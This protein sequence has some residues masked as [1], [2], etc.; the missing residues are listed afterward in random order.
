MQVRP[1]GGSI[2]EDRRT[3]MDKFDV[4]EACYAYAV[5]YHQGQWSRAYRLLCNLERK[6]FRAGLTLQSK[7]YEALSPEARAF[8]ETKLMDRS[9]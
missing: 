4:Y 5:D 1:P 8:Y 7:T 9:Y 6:G 3:E 2:P